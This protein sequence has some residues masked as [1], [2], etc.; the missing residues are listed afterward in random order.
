MEE[1]N[2]NSNWVHVDINRPHLDV[3]YND[4]V[5]SLTEDMRIRIAQAIS[6]DVQPILR[7]HLAIQDSDMLSATEI[8]QRVSQRIS[9]GASQAINTERLKNMNF[10]RINEEVKTKLN[11]REYID[12][13]DDYTIVIPAPRAIKLNCPLTGEEYTIKDVH[14]FVTRGS[15]EVCIVRSLGRT[16]YSE[17]IHYNVDRSCDY[18]GMLT[19]INGGRR[20]S[21]EVCAFCN[22]INSNEVFNNPEGAVHL[23]CFNLERPNPSDAYGSESNFLENNVSL[24]E[25]DEAVFCKHCNS[26]IPKT[27]L[28]FSIVTKTCRSCIE[29]GNLDSSEHQSFGS[30]VK[31]KDQSSYFWVPDMDLF[32]AVKEKKLLSKYYPVFDAKTIKENKDNIPK[33]EKDLIVLGLGSAGS[34]LVDQVSRTNLIN[35]FIFVDYD[36]VEDKNLRNQNY[37]LEDIG[38]SKVYSASKAV[39]EINKKKSV[40]TY[41][42]DFNNINFDMFKTKYIA[43][44][45]DSIKTRLEAFNKIADNS[46]ETNYIID[47]RYNDLYASIYLI[48]RNSE[49]EMEYYKNSLLVDFN[50]LNKDKE[51]DKDSFIP[52]TEEELA[53]Y[54]FDI[55][56]GGCPSFVKNYITTRRSCSFCELN[57]AEGTKKC[58]SKE[59][60]DSLIS[61]LNTRKINPLVTPNTT[62]TER[63]ENS[64]LKQNIIDIYKFASTFITSGIREIEE[65]RPKQ[66]S[67]VEVTTEGMPKFMKI[68]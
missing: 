31:K 16:K 64:C 13:K 24:L 18:D 66:F 11:I 53:D 49:E 37:V 8:I 56:M 62:R 39:A 26:F 68:R 38:Y 17:F 54:L 32:R 27:E 47:L 45:F 15:E 28:P 59:C 44:A 20:I 25:K 63:R 12:E 52:V 9:E 35:S 61:Y 30:F 19:P 48:D 40:K 6:R 14:F 4:I 55:R 7:E 46:I 50:N 5:P 57:G 51:E 33:S 2:S 21:F 34:N 23:L 1:Q 42:S 58:G 10:T 43:L 29:D 65:G 60:K 36:I 3:R 67:H 41:S 22:E